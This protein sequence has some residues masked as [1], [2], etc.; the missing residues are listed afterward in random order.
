[1]V[2]QILDLAVAVEALKVGRAS[3]AEAVQVL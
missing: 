3:L 1:V 2:L